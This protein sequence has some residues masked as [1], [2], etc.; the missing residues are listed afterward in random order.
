MCRLPACRVAQVDHSWA[1]Q[2]SPPSTPSIP[3][4]PSEPAIQDL[5]VPS[6][7]LVLGLVSQLWGTRHEAVRAHAKRG[8]QGW[9]SRESCM[10]VLRFQR[11]TCSRRTMCEANLASVR[12]GPVQLLHPQTA[13]FAIWSAYSVEAPSRHGDYS[14]SGWVRPVTTDDMPR[15]AV[16][17]AV[18]NPAEPPR[19]FRSSQLSSCTKTHACVSAAA[20]VGRHVGRRDLPRAQP[21]RFSVPFS[22][23]LLMCVRPRHDSL[24]ALQ[25]RGESPSSVPPPPTLSPLPAP[26][27]HARGWG[28]WARLQT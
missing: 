19:R 6:P 18:T 12:S 14:Q 13:R 25:E 5:A 1:P 2:A 7:L 16:L 15:I 23:S 10:R 21:T 22:C 11:P 20:L 8:G 4:Q 9:Q 3:V 17:K 28:S 26:N 24:C 27:G